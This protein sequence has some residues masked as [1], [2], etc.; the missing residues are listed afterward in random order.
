M[1]P[2]TSDGNDGWYIEPFFRLRNYKERGKGS[3]LIVM[4]LEQTRGLSLL[5]KS[6]TKSI[7]TLTTVR[8]KYRRNRLEFLEKQ[9]D[10]K[11]RESKNPDGLQTLK[12]SRSQDRPLHADVEAGSSQL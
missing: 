9:T 3:R 6:Q 4:C 11:A 2:S 10:E 7:N 8:G 5:L 1:G 12:S